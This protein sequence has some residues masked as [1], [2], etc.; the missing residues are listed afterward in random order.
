MFDSAVAD[1]MAL[2]A[3]LKSLNR[4]KITRAPTYPCFPKT[5][6]AALRL[7]SFSTSSGFSFSGTEL[8]TDPDW[9]VLGSG[10]FSVCLDGAFGGDPFKAGVVVVEVA[11]IGLVGGTGLPGFSCWEKNQALPLE[12]ITG[13]SLL[14]FKTI[15]STRIISSGFTRSTPVFHYCYQIDKPVRLELYFLE[16]AVVNP[17]EK[18]A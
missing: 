14:S 9:T 1:F 15:E 4:P 2:P 8:L 10:T 18:R 5:F 16:K 12:L 6:W 13:T 17:T 3:L 11:E 7:S